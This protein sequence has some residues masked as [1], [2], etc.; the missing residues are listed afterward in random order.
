MSKKEVELDA[1][2]LCNGR[3][4][5][6]IQEGFDMARNRVIANKAGTGK[7]TITLMIELEFDDEDSARVSVREPKITLPKLRTTG[8]IVRFDGGIPVVDLVEIDVKNRQLP[9]REI[10]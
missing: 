3:L 1:A 6:Y 10:K 4:H 7:A 5:E 2:T 8:Q 9:L